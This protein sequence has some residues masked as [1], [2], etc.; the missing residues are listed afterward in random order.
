MVVLRESA[1]YAKRAFGEECLK[2]WF[3]FSTIIGFSIEVDDE[4]RIELNPDRPDLYSL[5]TLDYA[6]RVY[7]EKAPPIEIEFKAHP[8]TVYFDRSAETLRRYFATFIAKGHPIGN[9]LR[10]LIDYQEKLHDSV[11]RHRVKSSIGIHDYDKMSFPLTYGSAHRDQLRFKT[12]DGFEG[13][14]AEILQNHQKGIEYATLIPGDDLVPVITDRDGGLM[15]MP[16]VINGSKSMIT[17]ETAN[18]LVD[19]TGPDLRAVRST[20]FLI[21]NFLRVL[22]YSLY[23]SKT[24]GA[25]DK[26]CIS[27]EFQRRISLKGSSI[28]KILGFSVT[29]HECNTAMKRMGYFSN[30]EKYPLVYKIPGFRDDVMG[31]VDLIEDLAKSLGYDQIPEKEIPVPLYGEPDRGNAFFGELRNIFIGAGFQEVLSLT[32][33]SASFYREFDQESSYSILN[34]KNSEYSFIRTSLFPGLLDFL[35]RNRNRSIPQR[36]FEVGHVIEGM[37]QRRK[38]CLVIMDQKAGYSSIKSVA[39][40]VLQRIAGNRATVEPSDYAAFIEGRGGT[41]KLGKKS[42]GIIGELHPRHLDHFSLT[43]PV[44]IMELYVDALEDAK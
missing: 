30:G 37:Q 12:Y 28:E 20:I 29:P 24:P 27:P 19:V 3:S 17:E 21:S 31:E 44:A 40:A 36:I 4:V 35:R 42:I 2:R 32:I 9:R 34:P 6:S 13:T 15:S 25:Y 23:K 26:K 11:G 38:A 18:F 5:E 8:S 1:E 16:P 41:L 33:S 22:G 7:Y 10:P 39:D 14:A 43:F